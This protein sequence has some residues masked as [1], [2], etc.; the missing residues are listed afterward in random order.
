[1]LHILH[2]FHNIIFFVSCN[3]HIL[4]TGC[5]KILKKIAAPKV[6]MVTL[7]FRVTFLEIIK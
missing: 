7:Q 2:L 4:N 6:N 1:M 3:I 5:A